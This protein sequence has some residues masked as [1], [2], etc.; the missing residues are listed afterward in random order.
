MLPIDASKKFLPDRRADVFTSRVMPGI[1]M[2]RHRA[3]HASQC[4]AKEQGHVAPDDAA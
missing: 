1:E 2:L 4:E 3:G